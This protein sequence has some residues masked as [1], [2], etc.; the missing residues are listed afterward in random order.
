METK[1]YS[2]YMPRMR[3]EQRKEKMKNIFYFVL[4]IVGFLL[5]ARAD[6]LA[7]KMGII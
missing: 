6:A 7:V 3:R 4:L 1:F 5:A 2:G